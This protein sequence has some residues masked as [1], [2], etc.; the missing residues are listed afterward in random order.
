MKYKLVLQYVSKHFVMSSF[1]LFGLIYAK[2]LLKF[3]SEKKQVFDY[4]IKA[5]WL[6]KTIKLKLTY[7]ALKVL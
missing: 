5:P 2:F 4:E 1:K 7:T 3:N 6:R